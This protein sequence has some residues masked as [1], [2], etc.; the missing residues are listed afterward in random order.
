MTALAAPTSDQQRTGAGIQG[1]R[2]PSAASSTIRVT[3]RRFSF[4]IDR[5]V[6][7]V[8][9]LGESLVSSASAA[10]IARHVIG[11]AIT[12]VILAVFLDA[13]HRVLGFTEIARGTLNATRFTPRDVLVP[14]LHANACQVILAHNHPSGDA[15]PSRADQ[16]VTAV[17]REATR[18]VGIPL[19]DHLIVTSTNHY[20]FAAAE[21][22]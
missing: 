20:S 10:E 6:D 18:T 15:L 22:W 16:Q 14:A 11:D 3:A 1:G 13:R 4:H 21:A 7:P 12:E 8:Y 17:M 19:A 5:P 2:G 9:P